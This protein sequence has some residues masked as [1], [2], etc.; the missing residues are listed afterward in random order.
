[1][2]RKDYD[3]LFDEDAYRGGDEPC[4]D[5]CATLLTEDGECPYGNHNSLIEEMK[6]E[7]KE[8]DST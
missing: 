4:C 2:T 7:E 1:M 3:K 8:G 5:Y 6:K